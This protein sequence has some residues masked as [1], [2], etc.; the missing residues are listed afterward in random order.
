MLLPQAFT[1]RMEKLLGS[2]YDAFIRSYEEE[3][4]GGLRVNTLKINKEKLSE[5][6]DF[7]LEP[8][9]WAEEGF[10]YDSTKRPGKHP[11]HEAGLYYLQEPS[12]MSV[13]AI[14][15]VKKGEKVLDLCGAPGGKSTALAASLAGEGLLIANEIHPA[16]CK[17]LSQNIERMG[18]RNAIVTNET[19]D[20]LSGRLFGFFDCVVVDAPCSGEGMFRKDEEAIRQWSEENVEM[21]AVRQ[22]EIL[23]EAVKMVRP[24][25]RLVYSTCTF[26]PAENEENIKWLLETY[27]DFTVVSPDTAEHLS[28]GRPE[29]C[30]GEM[31]SEMKDAIG[32]TVRLWPHLLKGEGHFA[33]LLYK[34][35]ERGGEFP[36]GIKKNRSSGKTPDKKSRAIYE[37]F[38]KDTL[39]KAPEGELICFGENLYLLPE[40]F[41]TDGHKV[42]RPGLH[43]GTFIKDRFEP[44]HS[45][46]LALKPEEVKRSV[47]IPGNGPEAAAYIRGESLRAE[48]EKGWCLVTLDGFSVGW[49]KASNG[50]IKNHYPKGLRK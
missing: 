4:K 33:A 44:S 35:G 23:S 1:S 39:V 36:E 24:G 12:A 9:P 21:C 42:L 10:Y 17:I 34:K 28:P 18:V 32:K 20:G 29:W 30:S 47:V 8:V 11:F 26:S 22:R 7:D 15:N 25:G 37:E 43:L 19:P 13:A 48:S 31:S 45:L 41:S 27:P 6:K 38:V 3:P 14:A 5:L 50:Q 2:E 46:A 16:R 49:G 40:T